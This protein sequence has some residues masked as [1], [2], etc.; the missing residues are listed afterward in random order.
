VW[1]VTAPE[2]IAELKKAILRLHG[3]TAEHLGSA[4]VHEEFEGET[5]WQG[6]VEVF[7]LTDH[8]AGKAYAWSH[9]ADSGGRR[10]VAVLHGAPVDSPLKAVQAAIVA[11]YRERQKRG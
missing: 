1:S 11:E 4:P 5:V 2:E 6:T 7:K 10:Y 9:E 8:P 3:A